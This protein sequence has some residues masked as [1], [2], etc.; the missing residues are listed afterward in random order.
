M[1][2]IVARKTPVV[3][4]VEDPERKERVIHTRV[5]KSLEDE[6]RRRAEDL[7]ISVS[8]LVRN[9]LG[10]TFGLVGDVVTDSR[11]VARA[12]RG[13]RAA[14]PVRRH[15]K[16]IIAWQKISVAKETACPRCRNLIAKGADAMIAIHGDGTASAIE[17][18]D[19]AEDTR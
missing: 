18:T 9:V 12:A 13:A 19:C 8:N 14:R 1:Y 11:E 5:P 16:E 2:H 15:E 10:H 4:V 3:P 6:L 17:C 7:G